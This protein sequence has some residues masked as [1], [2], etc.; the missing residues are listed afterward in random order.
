M[1]ESTGVIR[2]QPRNAALGALADFL[3]RAN[4]AAARVQFNPQIAPQFTLADLLPLE[5]AAGLMQDVAAYGPRALIKGGNVATGGIGTFRPDPRILDVAEA[6]A[7]GAPVARAAA[8]PVGRMAAQQI[9][10]AMSEGRGPLGAALA[11]VRPLPL[12]V[13]HGTPHRFPA[14][15][16]APFGRFKAGPGLATFEETVKE[17]SKLSVD[18]KVHTQNFVIEGFGKKK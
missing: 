2:P 17:F 8:R 5:G 3:Q 10:R 1:A 6:A 14:E 18:G 12:D 15:E 11:P 7:I 9:E 4:T 13:Y 16:G